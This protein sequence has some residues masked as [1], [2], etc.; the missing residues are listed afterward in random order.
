M[1]L[2]EVLKNNT[3]EL[4]IAI[5]YPKFSLFDFICLLNQHFCIFLSTEAKFFIGT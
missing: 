1:N 4:K 5:S 2:R 3:I